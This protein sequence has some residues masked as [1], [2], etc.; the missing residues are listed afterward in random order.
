MKAQQTRSNI[1]PILFDIVLFQFIP[2]CGK[3]QAERFCSSRPVAVG[4]A[5]S[6]ADKVGLK[7]GGDLIEG[8]AAVNKTSVARFE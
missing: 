3:T 4:L 2:E 6:L 8:H 7:A 1:E 5:E